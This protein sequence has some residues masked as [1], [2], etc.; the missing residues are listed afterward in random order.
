MSEQVIEIIS[1]NLDEKYSFNK[2]AKQASGAVL[3]H[4]GDAV[5]LAAVAIDPKPVEGDFT[6]CRSRKTRS[7][8]SS[9]RRS[10]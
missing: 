2:V 1:N 9:M 3:Y 8:K 10:N 7:G 4:C 6:E 5:L